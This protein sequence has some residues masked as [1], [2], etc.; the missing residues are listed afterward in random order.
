MTGGSGYG[1]M[2]ILGPIVLAVAI[3]WAM[4]N[5]R[6]SRTAERR[7]E[8]ATREVYDDPSHTDRKGH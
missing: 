3:I 6:R 8:E 2:V 1:L 4:R 5:N 7:T